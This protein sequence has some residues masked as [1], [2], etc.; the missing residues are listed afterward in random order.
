MLQG[1][2]L[3]GA[4]LAIRNPSMQDFASLITLMVANVFLVA[5][6]FMLNDW[7]GLSADLADPNKAPSV[8]TNRG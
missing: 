4:A 1:P 3:L 7:A 5:H 6:I 8:F 2:P